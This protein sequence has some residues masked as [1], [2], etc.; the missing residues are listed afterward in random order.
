MVEVELD[1]TAG[2]GWPATDLRMTVGWYESIHAGTGVGYP[3]S[4]DAGPAAAWRSANPSLL[5]G[6]R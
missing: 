2:K 5:G 1:Y 3:V 4:G 6:R